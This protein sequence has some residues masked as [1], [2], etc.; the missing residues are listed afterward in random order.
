ML[1]IIAWVCDACGHHN[2]ESRTQCRKCRTGR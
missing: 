2:P 1:V